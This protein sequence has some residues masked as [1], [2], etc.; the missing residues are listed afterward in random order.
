MHF[1]FQVYVIVTAPGRP[2]RSARLYVPLSAHMTVLDAFMSATR[3]Y[4]HNVS[5]NEDEIPFNIMLAWDDKLQCFVTINAVGVNIRR[6]KA[7]FFTVRNSVNE[8]SVI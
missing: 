7:W 6:R 3:E 8:V 5:V 2:Q 1:Q 4:M